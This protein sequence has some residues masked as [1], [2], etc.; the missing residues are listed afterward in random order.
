MPTAS[1]SPASHLIELLPRL[2]SSGEIAAPCAVVDTRA[3]DHNAARMRERAAGLPIRVA[4]KSLRSVAA[5]R[6]AL[7]HEGYRGILAYTLPEAINLVRE[8]FTDIVVAY[9]SVHTAA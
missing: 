6:R 5:L 7:N 1:T 8:G 9:P 3:F 2:I 4:S